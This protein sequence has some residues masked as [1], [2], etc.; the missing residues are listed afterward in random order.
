MV[1]NLIDAFTL[2]VIMMSGGSVGRT[3]YTGGRLVQNLVRGRELPWT[4]LW[5]GL[6]P[7]IGNL[8]FPMQI[9]RS[10]RDEDT[11]ARF[12]LYD[13]CR[14]IGRRTPIWGGEDTLTEHWFNRVPSRV[15]HR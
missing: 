1:S 5:V 8:A 14:V 6:F 10:G 3:I 2:S 9:V 15:L 11:I 7:V 13:G 12:L 4:A